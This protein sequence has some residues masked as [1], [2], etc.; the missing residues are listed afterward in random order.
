[1]QDLLT[2]IYKLFFHPR[3]LPRKVSF[4]RVCFGELEQNREKALTAVD[5]GN[6]VLEDAKRTL[7]T[8]KGK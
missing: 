7:E 2:K 4:I 5:N 6:L 1:M 8:L 3:A